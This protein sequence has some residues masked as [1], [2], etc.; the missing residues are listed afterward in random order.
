M[1]VCATVVFVGTCGVRLLAIPYLIWGDR[2]R[3][4]SLLVGWIGSFFIASAAMGML[5]ELNSHGELYVLL[6]MRLPMAVLT[7]AFLVAAH[8]RF[9]AWWSGAPQ[10][11]GS[12]AAARLAR[13]GLFASPARNALAMG[14]AVVMAGVLCVQVSLWWTRNSGGLREFL[15]TPADLKPDDYMRELQEALLWVR[16]NTE[17][18]AVLVANSCTPENMRKD[19]WGALDRTLTGVH[20]YYSAISERRLWFEGPNYIQDTTVA[21]NR[22]AIAANFFYRGLPL[23]SKVVSPDPTY[24]LLDRSLSDGAKVALPP[25]TRVFA[26]RRI[27]IYRLSEPAPAAPGD[28]T[29]VADGS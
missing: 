8:R 5:L 17:P 1:L 18:N 15:K 25:E 2:A 21:R 9:Q 28:S 24:V 12:P 6:M 20:F 23:R 16:N 11:I 27:E 19:H 10:S 14:A 3:R 29:K 22:A 7:G 13:P 4:D 26:N